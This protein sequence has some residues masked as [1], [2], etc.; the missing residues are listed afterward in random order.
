MQKNHLGH[1]QMKDGVIEEQSLSEHSRAVSAYAAKNLQELGL[2][3]TGMLA[4]LL[5]DSGK[6]RDTFLQYLEKAVIQGETVKRGSVNHTFAGCRYFL[7]RYD[8]PDNEEDERFAAELLGYACGAHHGLFDCID[9]H[10]QSG[11]FRRVNNKEIEYEQTIH[12]F[13]TEC[14][15]ETE[16]KQLFEEA[17][18][19]LSHLL[20]KIAELPRAEAE[21]ESAYSECNF[22]IGLL[23]RMILSAVIDA[24]CRDTA[25]FAK[26]VKYIEF[27][28]GE[29]RKAMWENCIAFMEEKMNAFPTKQPIE[30]ARRSISEQ[31]AAYGRE[32][33]G[34]I[35]LNV[36]TGGGKTLASLRFALTHAAIHNKSR[37]ILTSSLLSVLDQNAKVIRDCFQ[38][39]SMILEHHSNVVQPNEDHERVEWE[40]MV[41]RWNSPVIITTLVQLL[42]TM[43]S[44]KKSCIRR[45]HSLINSVIVIDEVQTVSSNLLT[46]FNLGINFLSEICGATVVLCSATQ[47]CLEEAAHPLAYVP[48]DMMPR[49]EAIWNVFQRTQLIDAGSYRLEELPGWIASLLKDRRS[50]LVICNTKKEAERLYSNLSAVDAVRYHLSAGMCMEHRRDVLEEMQKDLEDKQKKVVCISTQVIEA[51]VDISFGCVVRLC[52]GMDSI[53]QAAGRCNRNV[54][55][56]TPAPVYIVRC[57]DENLARLQDIQRGQEATISLLDYF[58][59]CPSQ[60]ENNLSSDTAIRYYY[61]KLYS[62]MLEGYQD[63]IVDG[64]SLFDLLSN[65]ETFADENCSYSGQYLMQQAFCTAGELFSV[66]D[67]DTW[68]VLVPYQKEGKK[69]RTE[70][71]SISESGN[72]D[73]EQID[74]LVQKAKPYTI[75]LYG[76]QKA[77]LE[78]SGA[79]MELFGGRIRVLLDG[80]YDS[81]IGFSLQGTFMED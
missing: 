17:V 7:E 65:N 77:V 6:A 66:F 5:H 18:K 8:T 12:N 23:E 38:N 29:D 32:P 15:S 73:Y 36:P 35:R 14:A 19:E 20:D 50:L 72:W 3:K 46:L 75:A 41:Q 4:G 11:F 52:A 79:W 71:I 33:G 39:Q 60:L 47:P 53:I 61:R 34:I 55:S 81:E 13:E 44:G 25:E 63:D 58:A 68:D 51:G 49:D 1:L 37:I 67:S 54:E 21:Q 78:K 9:D 56:T 28:D 74:Q 57:S 10:R 43:F 26:H 69:I 76:Y 27:P 31:C 80:F 59:K 40:Q 45:F 64:K 2:S 30:R 42:N 16:I 48:Y 24:D 70:L 22:Y 62:R